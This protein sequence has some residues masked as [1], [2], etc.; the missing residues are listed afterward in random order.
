MFEV[1]WFL[2]CVLDKLSDA[3][4]CFAQILAIGKSVNSIEGD[5]FGESG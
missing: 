5:K 4:K 1:T 3:F 2:E